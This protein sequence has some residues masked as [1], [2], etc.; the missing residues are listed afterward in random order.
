MKI[1]NIEQNLK[2]S[3]GEMS[4]E[5][6]F[7]P[8]ESELENFIS[9][10]TSF[11]KISKEKKGE[12]EENKNN[13][14]QNI[15]EQNNFDQN[16]FDIEI[17]SS[18]EELNELSFELSNFSEKEYNIY[19][20]ND[21]NYKENEIVLTFHFGIEDGYIKEI[22]ENEKSFKKFS[23]RFNEPFSLRKKENKLFLDFNINLE[24]IEKVATLLFFY[25]LH[26]FI[27]NLCSV[28]IKF[29]NNLTFEKF[30]NMDSDEFYRILS[31]FVFNL[32][33]NFK[34]LENSFAS[35]KQQKLKGPKDMHDVINKIMITLMTNKNMKFKFDASKE[36]I[37][38]FIKLF[39][40]KKLNSCLSFIKGMIKIGIDI[41]K[42]MFFY[43]FEKELNYNK[44]FIT[45]LDSKLKSGFALKIN[46]KGINNFMKEFK[47]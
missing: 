6:K 28:S 10:L 5:I 45:L 1:N 22:I 41:P 37:F 15:F 34:N 25:Y 36:K 32:K 3:K 31:S 47:Y 46:S 7:S 11:G 33:G 21:T 42:Q 19:Y 30:V 44:I 14:E 13:L 17:K 2:K 29:K 23:K 26:K 20:S 35:F 8:S 24:E 9:I 18:N 39:S 38:D 27:F 16:I 12:N 4:S 43:T 40:E